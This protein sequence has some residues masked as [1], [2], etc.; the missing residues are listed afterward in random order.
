MDQDN[1]ESRVY[2]HHCHVSTI[3]TNITDASCLR[4][5]DGTRSMSLVTASLDRP[6]CCL[7]YVVL[8]VEMLGIHIFVFIAQLSTSL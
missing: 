4:I 8:L 5:S 6:C 2:Q 1:Q 3:L 7:I